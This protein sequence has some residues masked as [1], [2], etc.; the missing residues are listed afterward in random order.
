MRPDPAYGVCRAG[1]A[2]AGLMG[3]QAP[4]VVTVVVTGTRELI[5]DAVTAQE[6]MEI[7]AELSGVVEVL[8][9]E[10]QE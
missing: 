7:A 3:A 1:Y 10:A 8:S 4:Y 6:A 5:V 9:A 2:V